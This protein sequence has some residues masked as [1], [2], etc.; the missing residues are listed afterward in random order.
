MLRERARARESVSVHRTKCMHINA[1]QC[2]ER[3]QGEEG[4]GGGGEER[5]REREREREKEREST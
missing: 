5:E 2:S 4:A 1:Y 3:E